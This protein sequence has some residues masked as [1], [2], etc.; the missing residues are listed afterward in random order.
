MRP[1]GLDRQLVG[2][3]KGTYSVRPRPGQQIDPVVPVAPPDAN[4]A[5]IPSLQHVELA[6][7]IESIAWRWSAVAHD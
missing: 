3:A 2:E 5:A 7:L 4:L 1:D 6:F